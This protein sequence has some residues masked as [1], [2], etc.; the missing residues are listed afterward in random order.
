M[1]G[2]C[3]IRRLGPPMQVSILSITTP[4]RHDLKG[5]K[6]PPPRD[7]HCVQK[8]SPQ[9]RTGSQKLNPRNIKL[10]NFTNISMNSDT[11]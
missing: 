11:I 9:D 6:T 7:N 10:E 8:P 2:P 3:E 5:A 4:P 1:I